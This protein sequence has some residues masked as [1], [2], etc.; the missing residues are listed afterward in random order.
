MIHDDARSA[1]LA[2]VLSLLRTEGYHF[3]TPT[4]ATHARVIARA[5]KTSA[6]N[7]QDVFGW[8]LPF[9]RALI[10]DFL[11]SMLSEAGALEEVN[12]VLKSKLRVSSLGDD[13]FLHSAF[14]TTQPNAV[15][16]GPDSYRFA[17]F[18]TAE[19]PRL[20][21]INRLADIGSGT[22]VGSI[23]ALHAT[24]DIAHVVTTDINQAAL[25]LERVNTIEACT[26]GP[27]EPGSW[28][29]RLTSGLD[30]VDGSF[31]CIIANPPYIADR[32]RRAYRDGGGMHGGELSL[33]WTQLA[34]DRLKQGGAFLLYTGSAIVDGEDLLQAKLLNALKGFDVTYEEIDPDV[35]GEE[36]EREDYADVDRIAV[37]GLVAVKR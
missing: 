5:S 4:P 29:A 2:S 23:A 10:S 31:D 17:S 34:A 16:F 36:L 14:P 1:A 19:L 20:G 13:L 32:A 15:F 18:I 21:A 11:F 37:V 6:R 9:E 22:G 35:F 33:K 7:M 28:D 25:D 26:W 27:L 8:N 12:G 30:G 3:I 24:P